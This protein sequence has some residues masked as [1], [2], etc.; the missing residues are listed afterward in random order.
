MGSEPESGCPVQEGCA[1]RR[2]GGA[3][4]GDESLR[5]WDGPDGGSGEERERERECELQGGR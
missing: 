1:V 3:G 4:S 2:A 5:S